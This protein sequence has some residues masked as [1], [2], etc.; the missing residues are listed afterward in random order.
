MSEHSGVHF[1]SG[2]HV[3]MT[4]TTR[5]ATGVDCCYQGTNSATGVASFD[6]KERQIRTT[7]D[8]TY[9]CFITE[10]QQEAVTLITSAGGTG[11]TKK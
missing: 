9:T 2:P 11:E 8:T 7:G 10:P 6:T 5:Q 3:W 1:E 4:R